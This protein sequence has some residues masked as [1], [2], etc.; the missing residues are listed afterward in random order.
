M[1]ANPTRTLQPIDEL[2]TI[3]VMIDHVA[4][5]SAGERWRPHGK[6]CVGTKGN[7]NSQQKFN[8][9]WCSLITDMHTRKTTY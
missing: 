1:H 8:S 3:S 2:Y 9:V 4:Y 7:K 6:K 5:V